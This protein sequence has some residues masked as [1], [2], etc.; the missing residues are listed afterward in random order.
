MMLCG[1]ADGQHLVEPFEDAG[2][3]TGRLLVKPTSEIANS[4]SALS[5]SSSSQAC[6]SARYA[7]ACRGMGSG[8]ITVRANLA[9]LDRRVLAEGATASRLCSF[10]APFLGKPSIASSSTGFAS[11]SVGKL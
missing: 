8:S 4:R 6:R 1:A 9:A 11:G 5:V 3:G 10:F 7:D 2:G